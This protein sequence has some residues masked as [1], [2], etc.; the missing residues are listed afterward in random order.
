M[1]CLEINLTISMKYLQT[2]NYE[3]LPREIKED[4]TQRDILFSFTGRLNMK[5]SGLPQLINIFSTM[6]I[7][8]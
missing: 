8:F 4:K 7:V 2:E 3:S 6:P 5:M 1:K